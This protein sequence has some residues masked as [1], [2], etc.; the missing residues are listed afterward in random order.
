ML[1][2]RFAMWMAW[3]PELTFFC[4]DAYL[5]TVGIKRDWVIGSRSDQVWAE[6]WPDIGPRIRHVLSAGE[7]TWDEALLLYLER[8][9]FAEETY[10]TFSYSPLA[11]DDG[12]IAGML[13]V[14]AEVTERVIG[15]R[16]LA[17]L[18]DLGV[19]LAGAATRAELMA[20]LEACL[21]AD[22]RDLP[23]ALVYLRDGTGR[24]AKLA[25]AHGIGK[26]RAVQFIPAN[27]EDPAATWPLDDVFRGAEFV[28]LEVPPELVD[29]LKLK[30]WQSPPQR[31]IAVPIKGAEGEAP[32]GALVAGLN[33]HRA[34]DSGYRGFIDLLTGQLSAAVARA[35][36]Y[37]RERARATALAEIDRAKTAFFSNISHES[38][39]PLTL[40]IGPLEDALADSEAPAAKQLDRVRYRASECP[41]AASP[42][43][44]VQLT[45]ER[46]GIGCGT[47]CVSDRWGIPEISKCLT[48]GWSA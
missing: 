11:D 1:T 9:G 4:N 12:D 48:H 44:C 14:V 20:A 8:S 37:E 43:A 39:T 42:R 23:F 46:I 47:L 30:H 5:P 7:A 13:C 36:D 25:A 2:S 38:R 31:A 27:L 41:S 32:V 19:R 10:H 33:P 16:Q 6:I 45:R 40:M 35:D 18:R 28:N 3:G 17:V 26:E 34:L 22:P 15:E 21:A 24:E 29:R